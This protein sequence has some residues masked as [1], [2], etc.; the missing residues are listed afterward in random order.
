MNPIF[1]N[2]SR[3]YRFAWFLAAA[4][5]LTGCHADSPEK[6]PISHGVTPAPRI[7]SVIISP[8][9]AYSPTFALRTVSGDSVTLADFRGSIVLVHFWAA[10]CPPCVR[11]IPVLTELRNL[12]QVQVLSIVPQ[13]PRSVDSFQAEFSLPYV[14]AVDDGSA[15]QAFGGVYS[16]PTTFLITPEGQV[17]ERIV[18]HVSASRLVTSFRRL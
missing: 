14:V 11:M 10:W 16:L 8:M 2:I 9:P 1:C 12:D 5:V 7:D 17:T 18:G 3:V 6:S 13:A 4:A 15:W